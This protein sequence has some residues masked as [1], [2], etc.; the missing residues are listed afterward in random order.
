MIRL[1]TA[2][3]TDVLYEVINDGA[4]AYKGVIPADRW[5]E[6]YMAREDLG[7][8]IAGGV[9]FW[10]DETGDVISAIMGIQDV[11]DVTLIRHAY[12]RTA[13]QRRGAGTRLLLHLLCETERPVLIGTWK[14]ATW[15]IDFY[16]KHGFERVPDA[17]VPGLLRHYW[18]I[19]DRQ[20]ETS[21]VLRQV[22]AD[23]G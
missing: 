21:V 11:R 20:I 23:T 16:R 15:A 7:R 19:P 17:E 5:H 14:A 6:P 1:A 12:V 4:R 22:V 13:S 8:E 3:D 10:V 9:V 2:D 18:S